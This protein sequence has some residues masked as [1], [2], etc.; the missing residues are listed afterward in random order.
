MDQYIGPYKSATYL[1]PS[2]SGPFL[3]LKSEPM[4]PPSPVTSALL[5]H[6]PSLIDLCTFNS[7]CERFMENSPSS[8]TSP[9]KPF[10]NPT[11]LYFCLPPIPKLDYS[12]QL[13]ENPSKVNVPAVITALSISSASECSPNVSSN[14]S[15]PYSSPKVKHL[16]QEPSPLDRYT[17]RNDPRSNSTS[18]SDAC[19]VSGTRSNDDRSEPLIAFVLDLVDKVEQM[20][21]TS[22]D[23]TRD[24]LS[25][26]A[27]ERKLKAIPSKPC[28]TSPILH[29]LLATPSKLSEIL[30]SDHLNDSIA[31]DQH[32][33]P[34]CRPRSP[35]LH[36][37]H[38]SKKSKSSSH[39]SS[40]K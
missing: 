21:E 39:N 15:T 30:L 24:W 12:Q 22:S 4:K 14:T 28:H 20:S 7:L 26:D 27:K 9:Y 16:L 19:R 36:A 1:H 2:P 11:E 35:P 37:S 10:I 17:A 34:N 33:S 3:E 6:N 31:N 38:R 8:S 18:Q 13:H 25:K 40:H 29:R 32:P 23:R 5:Q